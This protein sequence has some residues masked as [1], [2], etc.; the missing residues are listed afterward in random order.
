MSAEDERE[1]E[2]KRG[3]EKGTKKDRAGYV[4]KQKWSD[5]AFHLACLLCAS[6]IRASLINLSLR[7]EKSYKQYNWIQINLL[8]ESALPMFRSPLEIFIGFNID[9][10]NYD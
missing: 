4:V 5:K 9:C 8:R 7:F 10:G 3:R 1:R 2:R 6:S